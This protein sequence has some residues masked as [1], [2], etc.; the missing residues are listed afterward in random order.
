LGIGSSSHHTQALAA[1]Q[2]ALQH[3]GAKVAAVF[4]EVVAYQPGS[5]YWDFQW[6]ELGIYVAAALAVAGLCIWWVRRRLA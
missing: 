3:C 6:L 4:H 1:S 5:R 2:E